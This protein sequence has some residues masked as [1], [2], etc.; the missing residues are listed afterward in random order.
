[1]TP[2]YV[3]FAQFTENFDAGTTIPTGWTVINGGDANTWTIIDFT[4]A[5]ISAYS[6]ANAVGIGYGSTAH[7]DYLVTP[8]ITV[9]AGVSDHLSFWGR[10]RDPQYPEVISVK[11]STTG[12]APADFTI[13]L[14]PNVAPTSGANFYQYQYDLSAYVGQTIYIGFYS[15]TTDMFYFDIDDVTVSGTLSTKD[16]VSGQIGVYPNPIKDFLNITYKGLVKSVEIYNLLGQQVLLRDINA[17]E[18]SLDLSSFISGTYVARIVTND[19]VETMK[20]IKE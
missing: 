6:G 17:S 15:A 4:G 8:A 14:D 10:S 5:N 11:L 2:F 9:T 20:I 13:I 1:M 18:T 3:G 7:D 12:M 19:G 16:F